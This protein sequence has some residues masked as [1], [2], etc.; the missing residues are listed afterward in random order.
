MLC[1]HWITQRGHNNTIAKRDALVLQ[2]ISSFVGFLV[3][4]VK[5]MKG[6]E[7]WWKSTNNSEELAAPIFTF[8]YLT[9]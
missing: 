5:N 6:R 9:E 4:T 3:V 7:V 1:L 2:S 8:L